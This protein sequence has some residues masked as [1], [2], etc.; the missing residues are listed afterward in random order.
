MAAGT[1]N[2]LKRGFGQAERPVRTF[3]NRSRA[4]LTLALICRALRFGVEQVRFFF[5]QAPRPSSFGFNLN[6]SPGRGLNPSRHRQAAIPW[7][8]RSS[9]TSLT[10]YR[11]CQLVDNDLV[12]VA[13]RL[14]GHQGK[15]L[16]LPVGEEWRRMR[17]T[18]ESKRARLASSMFENWVT[19]PLAE[20]RCLLGLA[21][22]PLG[23]GPG[24]SAEAPRNF[25]RQCRRT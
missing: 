18:S 20:A 2:V 10:G 24:T 4:R 6:G 16:E 19:G 12:R 5:R 9:R 15:R 7:R 1:G 21:R 17:S 11:A 23:R 8:A 22:P 14:A 3:A 25:E 13:E